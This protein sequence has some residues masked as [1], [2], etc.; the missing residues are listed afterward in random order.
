MEL[1]RVSDQVCEQRGQQ[2]LLTAYHR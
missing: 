2:W 1:H